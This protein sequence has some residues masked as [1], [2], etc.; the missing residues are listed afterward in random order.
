MA[1]LVRRAA[2]NL[3]ETW[4]KKIGRRRA[5]S[6]DVRTAQGWKCRASDDRRLAR[7]SRVLVVTAATR[8]KIATHLRIT[9]SPLFCG[10]DMV[11]GVL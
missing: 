2:R 4:R 10:E 7:P 3:A 9:D 6:E 5:C 8:N 1:L 11:A